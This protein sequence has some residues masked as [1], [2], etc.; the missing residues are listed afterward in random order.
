MCFISDGLYRSCDSS[1]DYCQ[2]F[3]TVYEKDN[4]ITILIEALLTANLISGIV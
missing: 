1:I 3:R 4:A 2:K